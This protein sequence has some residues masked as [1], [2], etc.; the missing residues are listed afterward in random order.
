M[1]LRDAQAR[2]N[3][4][5]TGLSAA[6]VF[7]PVDGTVEQIYYPRRRDG[8]T[9]PPDPL[10]RAAGQRQGAFLRPADDAANHPY[11]DRVLIQCDGCRNDLIA[12]VSFISAQ[13]EF[14][15]PVIYSLEERARLVFRIE[16][17]P[18]RPGDLRIGQPASVACRARRCQ[19]LSM[20]RSDDATSRSMSAQMS[21]AATRNGDMQSRWRVSPSRST[22]RR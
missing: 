9:R 20:P 19:G 10:D 15:P 13:A 1:V 21:G 5:Q 6:A 16:A 4:S 22:E 2:L 17:I 11:G 3:S 18:E 7:S 12:R 14:T 8:R